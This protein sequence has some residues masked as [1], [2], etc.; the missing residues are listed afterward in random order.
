MAAASLRAGVV[1]GEG[2]SSAFPDGNV[3]HEEYRDMLRLCFACLDEDL[4]V[5][6][7]LILHRVI[8]T[9]LLIGQLITSLKVITFVIRA[10]SWSEYIYSL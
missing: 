10:G 5:E 3:R 4:L 7:V 9:G 6:A 8:V 2:T 1:V